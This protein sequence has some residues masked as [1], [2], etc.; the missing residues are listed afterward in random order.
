MG[1]D[2]Y[3]GYQQLH[4]GS[5]LITHRCRPLQVVRGRQQ[6]SELLSALRSEDA[7]AVL[8]RYSRRADG[9]DNAADISCR[10]GV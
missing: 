1:T 6:V 7:Q 4:D 8:S 3:L 10:S 2:R 5:V 9:A